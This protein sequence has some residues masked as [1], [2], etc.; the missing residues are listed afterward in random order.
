MTSPEIQE[1]MALMRQAHDMLESSD[2]ENLRSASRF[3]RESMALIRE[4][5]PQ[6]GLKIAR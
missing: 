4:S 3:L 5:D 6:R 1:A 2:N